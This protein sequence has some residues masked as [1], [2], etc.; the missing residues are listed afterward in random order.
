MR[1]ALKIKGAY[2][3]SFD[4]SSDRFLHHSIDVHVTLVTVEGVQLTGK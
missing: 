2:F 3:K 1:T 4:T